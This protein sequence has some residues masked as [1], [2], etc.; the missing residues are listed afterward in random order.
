MTIPLIA[1]DLDRTMIFSEAAMGPEQFGRLDLRCV[2]IHEDA[3][4]SYMTADAVNM[5]GNLAAT[6][7]VVPVTTRTPKQY[8]RIEL[9]GS[10][11]RYAV[12]SSGGRIITDGADDKRWRTQIDA[13]LSDAGADLDTV[14]AE[15]TSRI[16]RSWV[17]KLRIADDLFCYIV[18]HTERQ[19]AGFIAE[20]TG[21]CA[22]R[23]WTVSQQ[24]RKIYAQPA[25]VTKSAALAEVRRRLI[26]DG[27]LDAYAPVLAAGDGLL[28]ADMLEAADR[29]IRPAHGEL[30]EL[31][32]HRE[33]V[34]VTATAGA[35]AGEEILS[36]FHAAIPGTGAA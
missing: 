14:V 8:K 26:D 15:L 2:E 9:P 30:H 19:P 18:V 36:W 11:F 10:P 32:F 22:E 3:P 21:W 20:W 35:L 5:L 31:G 1:T 27:A 13:Q 6:A 25:T 34:R 28:D 29:G 33:H 12:V 23:G 24:G 17:K 16:D 4:L 7:P